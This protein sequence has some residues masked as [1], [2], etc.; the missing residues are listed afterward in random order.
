MAYFAMPKAWFVFLGSVHAP[1]EKNATKYFLDASRRK[2]P[3]WKEQFAIMKIFIETF[4]D[5]MR[6]ED[7]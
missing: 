5:N 2:T 6:F 7:K 4:S 3:A 1:E